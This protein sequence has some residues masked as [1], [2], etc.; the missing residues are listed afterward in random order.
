MFK[1]F[2]FSLLFLWMINECMAQRPDSI[3]LKDYRPKSIYK[4]PINTKSQFPL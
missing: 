3:L 1:A 2:L 4:I